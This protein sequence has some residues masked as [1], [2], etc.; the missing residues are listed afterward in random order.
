MRFLNRKKSIFLI[1]FVS[2]L[3][4]GVSLLHFTRIGDLLKR[5]TAQLLKTE[6][7]P[8]QNMT[9]ESRDVF[10]QKDSTY[11]NFRDH[12]RF[13]FQTIAL[14]KFADSSKLIVI[15][16][17]P[18]YFE[19]DSIKSIFSEFNHSVEIVKHPMGYD[20][21]VKDIMISVANAT[22]ENIE[23]R[24]K[25]LSKLLYL[26]DYKPVVTNLPVKEERVYF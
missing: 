26:S 6:F 14:A 9:L 10:T 24:I 20:G 19:V 2:L 1:T 21:F 15:S 25:Q 8:I 22:D 3:L 12:F 5:E 7:I 23:L 11:K 13:H 17:P 18:P 16:E 4:L